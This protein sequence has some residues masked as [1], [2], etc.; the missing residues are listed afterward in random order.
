MPLDIQWVAMSSKSWE[1]SNIVCNDG[2]VLF[3][4]NIMGEES[5]NEE[6]LHKIIRLWVNI[7]MACGFSFAK[8]VLE[9]YRIA[10]KKITKVFKPNCL[11]MN[12]NFCNYTY[13]QLHMISKIDLHHA[14]MR[15]MSLPLP[16]LK[17]LYSNID[18]NQYHQICIHDISNNIIYPNRS[19]DLQSFPCS[20]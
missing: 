17:R 9:K 16:L 15:I 1:L 13:I 20:W 2:N 4:W 14:L 5:S 18:A 7:C 12:L 19:Y 11:L 10:T 8:S 6:I 3:C